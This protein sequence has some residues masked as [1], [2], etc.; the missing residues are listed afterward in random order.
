MS[1]YSKCLSLPIYTSLNQSYIRFISRKIN[2]L[3]QT[4]AKK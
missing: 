2:F 4:Y 1:Y 3:I